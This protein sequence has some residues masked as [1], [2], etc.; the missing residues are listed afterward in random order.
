MELFSMQPTPP[1]LD[2]YKDYVKDRNITPANLKEVIAASAPVLKKTFFNTTTQQQ[3]TIFGT[4]TTV[5]EVFNEVLDRNPDRREL[6]SFAQ[7]LKEDSAFNEEKLRQVLISSEEFKRLERTQ[8]N[9]IYVNLQSNIT[10]RQITMAVTKAYS[11]AT[12][13]SYM[14]EDTMKFLKKKYVEFELN[15]SKLQSFIE[16]YLADQPFVEPN[17]YP[18]AAP[19]IT[20]TATVTPSSSNTSSSTAVNKEELD[21][22]KNEIIAQLN[23]ANKGKSTT[24]GAV[25]KA[26]EAFSVGDGKNLFTD[27]VFNFYSDSGPNR[28]V[29]SSLIGGASSSS[30]SVKTEDIIGKIKNDAACVFS[31]DEAALAAN[32]QEL[33]DYINSRNRSHMGALCDRNRTFLN[34]SDD[35]VLFPEFKWSVP[36]PMPPVCV[37]GSKS[38]PSPLNSQTALIGTLLDDAK[39]TQVGSVLP[40]FPPV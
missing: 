4:E 38:P 16:K 37:G 9:R 7:Q 2:F 40:V 35:M 21:R 17:P 10:D 28:E 12:G 30:G 25:A 31:K 11:K 29:I 18:K 24:H 13:K 27:N 26:T 22:L 32:K 36:Q 19:P 3:D 20:T 5:I 39:D 8:T 1:E 6:Y 34:A 23:E 14:D 33:A 15:D